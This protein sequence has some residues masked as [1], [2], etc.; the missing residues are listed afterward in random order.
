M[1]IQDYAV[2]V[3]NKTGYPMGYGN[4]NEHK[5]YLHATYLKSYCLQKYP[6]DARKMHLDKGEYST[7]FCLVFR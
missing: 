2:I 1:D 4:V 3:I 7:I 5:P 6:L